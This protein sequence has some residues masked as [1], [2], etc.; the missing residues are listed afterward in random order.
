MPILIVSAC[1]L[2]E[3]ENAMITTRTQTP[4]SDPF[5]IAK[6]LLW[7]PVNGAVSRYDSI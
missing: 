4:N 2:T 5:L 6:S 1:A 3:R 7:V